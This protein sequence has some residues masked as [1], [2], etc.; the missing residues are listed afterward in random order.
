MST[1]YE[2]G[3]KMRQAFGN[4]RISVDVLSREVEGSQYSIR[5]KNIN[6]SEEAILPFRSRKEPFNT[7]FLSAF[8]H[9]LSDAM[10]I[11][12][13]FNNQD[14]LDE[15]SERTHRKYMPLERCKAIVDKIET[16]V[17][18]GLWDLV[19]NYRDPDGKNIGRNGVISFT[20]RGEDETFSIMLPTTGVDDRM[21]NQDYAI[22]SFIALMTT[23]EYILN[24]RRKTLELSERSEKM[25]DWINEQN[26][27]EQT[28]KF[29]RML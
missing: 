27:F 4:Y 29:Q 28:T 17:N 9:K 25:F 15:F 20:P 5:L 11:E 19:V 7:D 16:V 8:W 14:E 21:A 23:S 1:N 2:I 18:Y 13:K 3:L 10:W 26:P 22:A 6:T 24:G 12:D